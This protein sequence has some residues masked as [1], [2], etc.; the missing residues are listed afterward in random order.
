MPSCDIIWRAW[1]VLPVV[2]R[3]RLRLC[4]LPFACLFLPGMP[5]S[6]TSASI[7]A[8]QPISEALCLFEFRHSHFF[9]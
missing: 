9:R 5:A 4:R 3:V 6:C 2:F 7:R 1:H 8:I